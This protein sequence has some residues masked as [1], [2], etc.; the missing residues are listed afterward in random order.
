MATMTITIT[1]V[2][3]FAVV[4]TGYQFTGTVN[5]PQ[6]VQ[7]P[8]RINGMS[9]Y[10]GRG[11]TYRVGPYLK[12]KCGDTE[13]RTDY[14]TI[15]ETGE[16]S[17]KERTL[18][19]IGAI[20]V[21]DDHLLK[22]NGRTITFT[23]AHDSS[24]GKLIDR[25]YAG[26][27]TLT[28]NYDVLFTKSEYTVS[29][30][31][32]MGTDL[33]LT[34]AGNELNAGYVHR[35]E[36]SL[37]GLTVTG[38]RTGPGEIALRIPRTEEWLT[39]IPDAVQKTGTVTLT[40]E[41]AG[42]TAAESKP[43]IITVPE[44][45]KP[46]ITAAGV[47]RIDGRVP[48]AWDLWVQNESA[49]QVRI[50]EAEPGTG[51]SIAGYRI[52]GAGFA[53]NEQQLT[54]GKILKTGYQRFTL[55]A[56]DARGR[57]G[58]ETFEIYVNGYAAPTIS[59]LEAVRASDTGAAN[60]SGTKIK[61]SARYS[62]TEIGAN[63][64][65]FR[66]IAGGVETVPE[67]LTAEDGLLNFLLS[68]PYDLAHSVEVTVEIRDGITA[69]SENPGSLT[70]LVPTANVAMNIKRGGTAAAF[71]RYAE[72]EKT[73]SI[74][75]DWRFIRGEV[76]IEQKADDARE[77]ADEAYELAEEAKNSTPAVSMLDAYPVGS[78]Y[79]SSV[80]TSPAELFGGTWTQISDKFLMAAGDTYA[81][82]TEGGR[83]S[84]TLSAAIGAGNDDIKSL[85]YVRVGAT[86]YQKANLTSIYRLGVS[87]SSTSLKNWNHSTPVTETTGT[88]RGVNIIP[89]Y[90]AV[91]VW[92]RT[93]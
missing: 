91:Y 77:K 30:A 10:Y 7:A 66:V 15:S 83:E 50:D 55:T 36:L 26:N 86:D 3:T 28:V 21:G 49:A 37:G 47:Y 5:I 6:T 65:E 67:S 33:V 73:L 62:L 68:G 19:I 64:P 51:S 56:T 44:D 76:D 79:M 43:L 69:G 22:V 85:A 45:V 13:F 38:S 82:G 93:A 2:P 72:T 81:A 78:I 24:S 57:T 4:N 42:Q 71:G 34:V 63:A 53:A 1:D 41:G 11:R 75:E 52:E 70:D 59:D 58:Q 35:A 80:A 61:G 20:N 17:A 39:L 32:D 29:D 88:E 54:T 14:F 40:T 60:D 84:V 27:M 74:P 25:P 90:Q 16:S 46:A 48:E 31:A 92:Q 89:P 87:S 18:N 12:V 23:A 9:L 8:I